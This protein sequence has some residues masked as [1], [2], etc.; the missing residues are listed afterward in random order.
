MM[1]LTFDPCLLAKVSEMECIGLA[2]IQV[3]DSLLAGNQL[4]LDKEEE[5]LQK[6]GL[7]AKPRETL[8]T[9]KQLIFNGAA[10]TLNEDDSITISQKAQIERIKKVNNNR[11][12]I[13]Q[14]ARGS[15]IAV[16]S[17]PERS[18]GFAQAA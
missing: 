2:G 14:R 11:D 17:H 13:S 5:E 3:D 18:F 16:T 9:G 12:F 4:F 10:L 8:Q 15:Y 6:A 7:I 1:T